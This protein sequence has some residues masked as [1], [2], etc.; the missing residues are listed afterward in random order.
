MPTRHELEQG[1][2]ICVFRATETDVNTADNEIQIIHHELIKNQSNSNSGSSFSRARN[3][4][5]LTDMGFN[6]TCIIPILP[7]EDPLQTPADKGGLPHAP[8]STPRY[9]QGNRQEEYWFNC[10]DPLPNRQCN[11]PRSQQEFNPYDAKKICFRC[12][13]TFQTSMG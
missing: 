1:D 13:R 10:S 7:F 9:P 3:T 5:D 4:D 6:L 2:I 8:T 12:T 11:F